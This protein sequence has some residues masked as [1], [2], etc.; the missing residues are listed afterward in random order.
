MF[1]FVRKLTLLVLLLI[2]SQLYGQAWSGIL[3]P[4]R[5][6]DWSHAGVVGGIPSNTWTQCGSTLAAGSSA[7]TI[8]SAIAACGSNQYV[9]LAAGTYNLSAAITFAGKAN[10]A[11]RGAGANSTFLVFAASTSTSCGG[12][13]GAICL[14]N[15]AN[16][17]YWGNYTDIGWSSGFA[18][19]ATTIT[20]GSVAGISLNSTIL[21]VNQ[22]NDGRT[23]TTCT[24]TETDTGNLYNCGDLYAT[25]PS[26]CSVN[27]QDAGN[28]TANRFQQE[29]FYVTNIAGNVVTLSHPLRHPNWRSGQ[30][31]QAWIFQPVQ[32]EGL[33]N[34]S[35][36]MTADTTTSGVMMY[37]CFNCWV[38][39]SR[40]VGTNYAGIYM[41][42]GINN[43][44]ESNYGGVTTR[45]GGVDS[46][47]VA[48]TVVSDDLIQNNIYHQIKSLII[49]EGPCNGDVIAYNFGLNDAYP[50][51]S[52]LQQGIRPHSNGDTYNLSEGNVLMN[53]Y[54]ED[55]H[56][57]VNMETAYRNLLQGWYSNPAVPKNYQ[58]N[59]IMSDA[60]GRYQNVVANVLGTPTLN[61][62]Y[63]QISG[64]PTSANQV[65]Y[66]IGLGNNGATPNIPSDP[67]GAS[68]LMRWGNYDVVNTAVLE[69][70]AVSTPI[71]ACLADERADAATTY[72]GLAS[73]STTFPASFYLS[74]RPSWYS[75]SI[76]FPAIGPDVSSGNVGVCSGTLNT[77]GHFSGEAALQNSQCT[78]TTLTT[79][80]WGGHANAI[81]AMVC[82]L[83][84]MGMPVDGSGSV[85]AFDA[86]ACYAGSAPPPV[87]SAPAKTQFTGNIT[88]SGTVAMK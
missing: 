24:G 17:T 35:I 5:A 19:G 27:G 40:F 31:P 88:S 3:A 58:A 82:A 80:A 11:L 87:S 72:P 9:S 47:L 66:A 14:G 81:P 32:Y 86:N 68:T 10:V 43:Q 50:A 6:T 48:R 84:T 26:G 25:T 2:A 23:G 62:V 37:S 60:F 38:K 36:D 42:L 34:L 63:Q 83:N 29:M 73:P 30:T 51:A 64:V 33:E 39:G 69:C 55:Y 28:G 74:S 20:L 57:T 16:T 54:W 41:Q 61:T 15:A 52:A 49:G 7:A 71:A 4:A 79:S 76:P 45:A 22:C 65:I 56:G 67:L 85:L 59:P 77:T 53:I 46:F 8:N 78:G 12:Y 75:N 18:Q 1:P 70:T 44:V 13:G 21:V